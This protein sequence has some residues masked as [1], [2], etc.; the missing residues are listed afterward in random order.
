M[1]SYVILFLRFLQKC[2]YFN[3]KYKKAYNLHTENVFLVGRV[4]DRIR[5]R[6]CPVW[7]FLKV[8]QSC[9]GTLQ[10]NISNCDISIVILEMQLI[11]RLLAKTIQDIPP[12]SS[13]LMI[14]L[15]FHDFR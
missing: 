11:I 8:P 12:K 15:P 14:V 2:R 9:N 10:W 5:K 6:S 7:I 4:F 13:F 3:K 1:T